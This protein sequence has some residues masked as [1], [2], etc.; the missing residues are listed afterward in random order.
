MEAA[1]S[2]LVERGP[3][4]FTVEA[5]VERT[6]VAKTTI[7]RHWPTRTDLLAAAMAHLFG[8]TR[9]PDTGT[10]RGDLLEFFVAGVRA[11]GDDLW[12]RRLQSLPGIMEAARHD[13]DLA[14]VGAQLL[15]TTLASLRTVLERGRSRGEVRADRD[16]DA[17]TQVL[18]G[19]IFIHRGLFGQDSTERY[20]VEVVDTVLEGITPSTSRQRA[21]HLTKTRSR[22]REGK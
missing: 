4:G 21:I 19:A 13:P 2:L 14:A 20:V 10:L 16:L 12:D 15:N 17:M 8:A 6:G 1:T 5:I 7:Y 18:L 3:A 22:R 11:L 9:V